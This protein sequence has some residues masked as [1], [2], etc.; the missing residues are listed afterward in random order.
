MCDPAIPDGENSQYR[1]WVVWVP[2]H[3]EPIGCFQTLAYVKARAADLSKKYP[4]ERV[5]CLR[6]RGYGYTDKPTTPRTAFRLLEPR[7]K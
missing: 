4:G 6:A 2:S 5:Y 7:H 3:G 1:F